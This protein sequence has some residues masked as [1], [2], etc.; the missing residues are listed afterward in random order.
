MSCKVASGMTNDCTSRLKSSGLGKNFWLGYKSDLD[1]QISQTQSADI[2]QLDLGSYGTLYKFEGSKFA[3][4]YTW[5]GKFTPGGNVSYDHIFNWKLNA[6]STADDLTI[7]KLNLGDDIF[8]IVET[9]NQE[10]LILGS[11]NG[12]AA[13]AA[14]GGSGGKESGGDTSDSGTLTANEKI[15]PL[16]FTRGDGY[17]GT[18][19]YLNSRSS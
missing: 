1:T 7:Q 14:T 5:E 16:R 12:M 17:Q 13:T 6:D 15:K 4:D 11:G 10:F 8:I 3:H 9:T 2:S 19:D 18:L